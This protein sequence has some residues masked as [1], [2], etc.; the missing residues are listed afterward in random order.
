MG[1]SLRTRLE[2]KLQ[3]GHTGLLNTVSVLD[4]TL[5]VKEAD[6]KL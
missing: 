4:F 6:A 1:E 3:S 2:R 5:N